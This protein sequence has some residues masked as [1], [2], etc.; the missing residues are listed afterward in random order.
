MVSKNE[1]YYG[2]YLIILIITKTIAY[3]KLYKDKIK[4]M[5]VVD[6]I[7]NDIDANGSGKVDFTEFVAAAINK[8]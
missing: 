3:K 7:F 8:E 4:A 6:E 2:F 1:L 5:Q